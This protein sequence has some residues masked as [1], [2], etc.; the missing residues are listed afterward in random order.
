MEKDV[1]IY[2]EHILLLAK[3]PR[4][5]GRMTSSTSG[6]VIKGPC[7]DEMEF[8]LVIKNGI[9]EEV[10]FYTEGCVSTIAYGEVTARLASG[11]SIDEALGISPRQIKGQLNGLPENH[12]HCSI[13]A[14]STLYKAIANYLLAK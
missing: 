3:N 11:K 9:I 13:L 12:S 5:F 14:A 8:Y 6:A 7:G 1:V 10:K 4:H 2:P